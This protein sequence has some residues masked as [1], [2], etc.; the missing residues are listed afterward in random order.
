MTMN[1]TPPP[2]PPPP[3]PPTPPPS[4]PRP[5]PR[6]HPHPAPRNPNYTIYKP[7]SRGTGGAVRFSLNRAK[8]S[9]FVE[10]ANQAG[11]KQFDWDQKIIMKWGLPDLGAVLAGLHGRTPQTKLF[12]QS[13][14]ANSA[15]TLTAADSPEQ[16][17]FLLT[18]SRQLSED[19]TLRKV[20]VP[21]TNAEVAV[22]ETAFRAAISRLLGW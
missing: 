22:L 12:H 15:C 1:P 10:A 4:P 20:S 11:D 7:N 14:K 3:P 17:P 5:P 2:P 19:K 18:V 9:V 6:P 16:A 13:D 21:L 8:A